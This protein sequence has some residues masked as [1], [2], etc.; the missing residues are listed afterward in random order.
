MKKLIAIFALFVL[1]VSLFPVRTVYASANTTIDLQGSQLENTFTFDK[2]GYAEKLLVGPFDSTSISFGLPANERLAP[3]SSL[4]LKYALAW[5]GGGVSNSTNSAGVGG[6]LLVYF[7]DELI[8][9]IILS[10]DSPLEKE[11]PIP[12]EALNTVDENGRYNLSFS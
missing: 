11:I 4:S 9:T 10:T 7:N 1:F 5:S 2:L 3:G 6:T 12:D 8:D